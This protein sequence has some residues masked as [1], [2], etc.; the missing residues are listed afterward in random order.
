[1]ADLSYFVERSGSDKRDGLAGAFLGFLENLGFDLEGFD[2]GRGSL[3]AGDG[4]SVSRFLL[5]YASDR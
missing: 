3:W 4:V 5:K 1:M 2:A